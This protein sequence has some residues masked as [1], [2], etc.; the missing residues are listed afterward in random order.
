WSPV[1]PGSRSTPPPGSPVTSH[2]HTENP[3]HTHPGA[4]AGRPTAYLPAEGGCRAL[5]NNNTVLKVTRERE[6]PPDPSL[7]QYVGAHHSLQSAI[8]DIVDNSVSAGATR[9]RIRFVVRDGIAAALQIIDDGPGMS[10]TEVDE[11]MIMGSTRDYRAEELG[12]VD[13]G[14]KPAS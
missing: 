9:I 4:G 13:V 6:V 1:A 2:S 8:A 5:M 10:A 14:F 3:L 11:A 7:A 12:H